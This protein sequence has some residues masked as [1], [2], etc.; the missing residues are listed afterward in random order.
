MRRIPGPIPPLCLALNL[1]PFWGPNLHTP[2]DHALLIR[3]HGHPT[4]GHRL[5]LILGHSRRILELIPIRRLER[6]HRQTLRQCRGMALHLWVTRQLQ[7]PKDSTRLPL[8]GLVR[9][10]LPV[11]QCL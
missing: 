11:P 7:P 6:A 9:L 8:L 1:L 5:L 4:L 3:G 2:V 10:A